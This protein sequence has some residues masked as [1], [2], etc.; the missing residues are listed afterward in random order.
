MQSMKGNICSVPNARGFPQVMTLSLWFQLRRSVSVTIPE[1]GEISDLSSS[2]SL[3]SGLQVLLADN[4]DVNRAVT[5]KFLRK[6][7]CSVTSVS[8][9]YECLSLVVHAGASPFEVVL[10]DLH[11]PDL[12]G[13][14]FTARIRKFKSRNWP[15][16]VALTASSEE[17]L[18]Q[19]CMHIGFNGVIRKP[20][21]LEGF[22]AELRRILNGNLALLGS[23]S[24]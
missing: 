23:S 16:V 7:G 6:L 11:L 14:E 3:F 21:L 22:A 2:N 18:W 9:G 13:F 20:V 17:D 24:Y 19:K 12:D 4:D 15:I 8:S 10:L 1:P 5:Q